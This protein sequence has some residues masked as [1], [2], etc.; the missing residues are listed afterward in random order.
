MTPWA[1]K[2]YELASLSEEAHRSDGSF[3]PYEVLPVLRAGVVD[4]FESVPASLTTHNGTRSS[5]STS[6]QGASLSS[7]EAGVIMSIPS[8]SAARCMSVVRTLA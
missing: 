1:S 4:D 2:P 6:H 3:Q 5:T 8:F 7:S